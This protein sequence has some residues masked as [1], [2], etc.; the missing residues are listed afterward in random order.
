MGEDIPC[1][2]CLIP[3][4]P[5]FHHHTLWREEGASYN[6][7][8]QLFANNKTQ[9]NICSDYAAKYSP[10]LQRKKSFS[11]PSFPISTKGIIEYPADKGFCEMMQHFLHTMCLANSS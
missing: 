11:D 9:H 8:T 6:D 1:T 5:Q 7:H 3:A 2:V 4:V 10:P